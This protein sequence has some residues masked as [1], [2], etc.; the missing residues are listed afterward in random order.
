ML[1][2]V[3]AVGAVGVAVAQAETAPSFTVNGTRLVAGKTHNVLGAQRA[4]SANRFELT[5][6]TASTNIKCTNQETKGAVLLGSNAGEPGKDNEIS[7]FTGCELEKGNGAPA[8]TLVQTTITTN[9]LTSEQVEN[10]ENSK[11][12]KQLLEE[13][14]PTNKAIGFVTLT[15]TP[16]ASCTVTE[17]KISG[18]AIA[19]SLNA[20]GEKIE[21]PNLNPTEASTGLVHFPPSPIK[22][23]WLI[24]NGSG[25][26]QST[27]QTSFGEEGIQ[28]G[29]SLVLLANAN[30]VPEPS[31]KWSALP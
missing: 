25:K 20:K 27:E 23:V 18:Q 3:F 5:N 2:A 17:D 15:F 6:A 13:F 10:V 30:F 29:E 31:G 7:V 1:V 11:G 28:L 21:L 12:G 24:T 9:P 26:I 22:Q 14:R 19:E 4:G 16:K 8:C